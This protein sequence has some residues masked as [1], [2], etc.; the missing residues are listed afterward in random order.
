[1]KIISIGRSE[2][3]DIIIEDD[4][5][6]RR[7]AIIKIYPLG[8][9]EIVDFG[10]NG[11]F[12]NGIRLSNNKPYP[13]TRKDVVSFAKVRQ[14]NWSDVPDVTRPYRIGAL[15]VLAVIAIVVVTSLIVRLFPSDEENTDYPVIPAGVEA[16]MD[17][18]GGQAAPSNPS[19]PD[20]AGTTADEK[21][22][23]NTPTIDEI[24][25]ERAKE[26]NKKKPSDSKRDDDKKKEEKKPD[27]PD[28]EDEGD[29]NSFFLNN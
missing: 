10:K 25:P 12:V 15:A 23:I 14:L 27:K 2:E 17:N 24:F 1:M 8:K 29:G 19:A 11:T 28:N 21:K 18:K 5:V 6:S 20:G 26:K 4:L 13:V 7:Q 16:P 9:M 3:C 22:E